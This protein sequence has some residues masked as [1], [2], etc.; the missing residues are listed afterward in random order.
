MHKLLEWEISWVNK[1]PELY[2]SKQ[3]LDHVITCIKKRYF[4]IEVK[5]LVKQ[6]EENPVTANKFALLEFV[7][8]TNV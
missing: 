6:L 7:K 8:N 3:H 2:E 4:V 5:N 1:H